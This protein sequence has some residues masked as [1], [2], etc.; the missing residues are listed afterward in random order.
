M[1]KT[2]LA[3]ITVI[4]FGA[5]WFALRTMRQAETPMRPEGSADLQRIG[6]A[7]KVRTKVE[8]WKQ[9]GLIDVAKKGLLIDAAFFVPLYTA[10]LVAGCLL[11]SRWWPWAAKLAWCGV[12]GGLFD[13]IENLCC[14]LELE[15]RYGLA[16]VAFAAML[17][18]STFI[19]AAFPAC[20]PLIALLLLG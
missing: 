12:A 18:K 13:E 19:L 16:P 8:A 1:T 3:V 2:T 14:Y 5:A 11:A 4:L 10:F 20:L 6:S 7:E 15:G 17:L 9:R